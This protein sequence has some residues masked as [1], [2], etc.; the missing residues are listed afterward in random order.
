MEKEKVK[1]DEVNKEVDQEGNTPEVE[2]KPYEPSLGDIVIYHDHNFQRNEFT[3]QAAIVT[4]VHNNGNVT[5]RV[6]SPYGVFDEHF[7]N[8]SYGTDRHQY[9]EKK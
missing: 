8:V 9:T 2:E 7:Q 4:Y 5:L 3:Q 1:V 6:L